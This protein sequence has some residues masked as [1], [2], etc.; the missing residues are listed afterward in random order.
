VI[1]FLLDGYS[2][3]APYLQLVQQVKQGLRTGLIDPGDQLPTVRAACSV[4]AV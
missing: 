2:Q 1:E 4:G 3:T